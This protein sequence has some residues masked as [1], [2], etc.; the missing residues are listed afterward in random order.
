MSVMSVVEALREQRHYFLSFTHRPRNRAE[1]NHCWPTVSP[2]S[3]RK[4]L[5]GFTS[6][7]SK[8]GGYAQIELIGDAGRIVRQSPSGGVLQH[9]G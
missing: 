2:E 6:V 7:Q 8:S 1:N 5:R 4:S 3:D 9:R